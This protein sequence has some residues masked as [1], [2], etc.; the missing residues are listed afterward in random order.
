MSEKSPESEM[1]EKSEET[2]TSISSGRKR[3]L[4]HR[5]DL[6]YNEG[7]S[8]DDE[9][10]KQHSSLFNDLD[11]D[12]PDDPEFEIKKKKCDNNGTNKKEQP[13][14][15]KLLKDP[16][17]V[18]SS[19]PAKTPPA[20]NVVPNTDAFQRYVNESCERVLREYIGDKNGVKAKYPDLEKFNLL[21]RKDGLSEAE[22]KAVIVRIVDAFVKLTNEKKQ[23][24]NLRLSLQRNFPLWATKGCLGY[25][26]E[27][28]KAAWIDEQVFLLMIKRMNSLLKR[29]QLQA[30][31]SSPK[32]NNTR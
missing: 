19:T 1:T 10:E 6:N 26:K 28:E 4:Q 2:L 16:E 31:S 29:Q 30:N 13:A 15:M 22:W 21:H 11:D 12:D 8:S 7:I 27:K 14:Y 17:P 3:R 32:K 20:G 25:V 18:K 5:I 9:L 23:L 24:I